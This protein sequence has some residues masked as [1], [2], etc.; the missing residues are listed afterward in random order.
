MSLLA[1]IDPEI[2]VSFFKKKR[3]IELTFYNI[4]LHVLIYL[5]ITL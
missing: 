2:D 1:P 4:I 3:K 5:S